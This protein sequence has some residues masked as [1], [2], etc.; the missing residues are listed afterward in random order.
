M[1]VLHIIFDCFFETFSKQEK[2]RNHEPTK[3]VGHYSSVKTSIVGTELGD[4][5][6][7]RNF[8]ENVCKIRIGILRIVFYFTNPRRLKYETLL[9]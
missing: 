1:K 9:F 2:T 6:I 8:P 7:F 3:I 4:Q 5:L